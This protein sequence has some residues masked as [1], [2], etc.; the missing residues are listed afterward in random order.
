MRRVTAEADSETC[1]PMSAMVRRA[2]CD[3]QFDDLVINRI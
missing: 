2:F 1:S 3:E